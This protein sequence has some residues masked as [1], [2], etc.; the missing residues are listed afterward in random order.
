M[1][2]SAPDSL[3]DVC[4]TCLNAG[5]ANGKGAE[6]KKDHSYPI[7]AGREESLWDFELRQR[8]EKSIL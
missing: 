7:Q 1:L 8:E 5:L 3:F 6:R 2:G 4:D